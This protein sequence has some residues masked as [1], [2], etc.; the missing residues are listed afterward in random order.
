M[1]SIILIIS[2]ALLQYIFF[3]IKVG[4]SRGKYNVEAPAVTGNETWERLYRVQMNTLE[5]LVVFI[6]SIYLFALNVSPLIA[7]LFGLSYLI[8]RVIYYRSYVKEP[9]SR[10]LGVMLS[11]MPGWLMVVGVL[12]V[13]LWTLLF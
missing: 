6:P 10:G 13:S 5:Q 9:S 7:Q 1:Q 11:I 2:L 4:T 12:G 8:G 3:C